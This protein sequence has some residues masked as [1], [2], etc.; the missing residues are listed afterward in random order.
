VLIAAVKA[1]DGEVVTAVTLV[2]GPVTLYATVTPTTP[3]RRRAA[4]KIT[5]PLS[6]LVSFVTA[7]VQ[8][9][10]PAVVAL[11]CRAAAMATTVTAVVEASIKAAL[12]TALRV[13]APVLVAVT[14]A[15]TDPETERPAA[16]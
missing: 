14:F 10:H 3:A 11:A 9:V 1:A 7:T 13:R 15:A 5:T 16:A 2:L 12:G 8:P 4:V 6:A